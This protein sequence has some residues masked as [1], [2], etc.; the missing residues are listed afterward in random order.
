MKKWKVTVLRKTGIVYANDEID[1][2]SEFKEKHLGLY[3]FKVKP[4]GKIVSSSSPAQLDRFSSGGRTGE[5]TR[6][7]SAT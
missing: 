4:L 6:I 1:A 2:I 7:F 3:D 5:G